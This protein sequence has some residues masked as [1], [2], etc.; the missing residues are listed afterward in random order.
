MVTYVKCMIARPFEIDVDAGI[1]ACVGYLIPHDVHVAEIFICASF[2]HMIT[3]HMTQSTAG[4][5]TLI[6]DISIPIG[7][8][9]KNS[10]VENDSGF[11][12]V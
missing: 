3:P 8:L 2:D 6:I 9:R 12:V 11:G 4:S 10:I 5:Q 7:S 1:L